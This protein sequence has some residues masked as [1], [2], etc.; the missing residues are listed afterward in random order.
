MKSFV[1]A[2]LFLAA[3][4]PAVTRAE[5]G[6]KIILNQ[7]VVLRADGGSTTFKRVQ[8]SQSE[9][10]SAVSAAAQERVIQARP[11]QPRTLVFVQAHVYPGVGTEVRC[12]TT[13]SEEVV[14]WSNVDFYAFTGTGLV[15]HEG[16]AFEYFMVI[17]Q[18]SLL[19]PM[20]KAL[21]EAFNKLA[22]SDHAAF[23]VSADGATADKAVLQALDA[24]MSCYETNRETLVRAKAA[25]DLETNRLR[26]EEQ[27]KPPPPPSRPVIEFWTIK[28][29][30][31]QQR[32]AMQQ[33]GG[34]KP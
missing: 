6:K 1:F 34:V 19:K 18:Q 30:R 29:G 13:T 25:R 32:P 7:T 14:A 31:E 10:P 22:R 16:Q 17:T 8:R 15:E 24:L 2:F 33:K 5:E 20:A 28:G 27:T 26:M 12:R 9:A 4:D 23:S 11:R 3:F 21:P